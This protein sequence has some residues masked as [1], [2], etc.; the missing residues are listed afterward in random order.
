[1]RPYFWGGSNPL[2]CAVAEGGMDMLALAAFGYEGDILGVPG[3]SGWEIEWFVKLAKA[4]GTKRFDTFF[5]NDID[6][7]KTNP[8][9]NAAMHWAHACRTWP[10]LEQRRPTRGDVNDLWLQRIRGS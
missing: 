4:R 10:R 3:T 7:P 1:V 2:G 9:Q 5:D 8:G 6:N